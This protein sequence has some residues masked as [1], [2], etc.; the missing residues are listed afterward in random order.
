MPASGDYYGDLEGVEDIMGSSRGFAAVAFGLSLFSLEALADPP[1]LVIDAA[2]D[3]SNAPGSRPRQLTSLGGRVLFVADDDADVERLWASDGTLEGTYAL[4]PACPTTPFVGNWRLVA[5]LPGV[6]LFSHHCPGVGT[7]L[8][9]TDG[10]GS[11]TFELLDYSER[12]EVIPAVVFA[13]AVL[14]EES[15]AEPWNGSER[16]RLWRTDGTVEGTRRV[17]DVGLPG[18]ATFGAPVAAADRIELIVRPLGGLPE[19]WA[20]SGTTDTTRRVTTLEAGFDYDWSYEAVPFGHRVAWLA[21]PSQLWVSD[22]TVAGSG[23]VTAFAEPALAFGFARL[24]A[25]GERLLFV[26]NDEAGD[27]IWQSDGTPAGTRRLTDLEEP[28]ALDFYAGPRFL[29]PVGD[30]VLFLMVEPDGIPRLAAFD[31]LGGELEELARPCADETEPWD[32][33]V[34]LWLE[35]I[36]ERAVVPIPA[37]GLGALATSDGTVA[38]TGVTGRLCPTGCAQQ[39]WAP[40]RAGE[41]LFGLITPV[42]GRLELWSL[43]AGG[44]ATWRGGGITRMGS[45]PWSEPL[46]LA[47]AGDLL[48]LS[49]GDERHGV[50]LFRSSPGSTRLELVRDLA[51]DTA[52]AKIE[53]GVELAGDLYLAVEGR[54]LRTDGSRE[55]TFEL[56]EPPAFS[57]SRY[58]PGETADLRP[59]AFRLLIAN[60]DCEEGNLWSYDLATGELSALLGEARPDRPHFLVLQEGNARETDLLVGDWDSGATELWTTDGTEAGTERLIALPPGG[61]SVTRVGDTRFILAHGLY[62]W[63]PED[64]A[65][66]P[67]NASPYEWFQSYG[68]A[69]GR[70]LFRAG[71]FSAPGVALIAVDSGGGVETLAEFGE[72][73]WLRT[74][75]A[76][77]DRLLFYVDRSEDGAPEVWVTD[78]SAAGTRRLQASVPTLQGLD[79]ARSFAALGERVAF[80]GFSASGETELWTSDGSE[81][82]TQF[83]ARLTL[84]GETV[85]VKALAATGDRI[86]V[87]GQPTPPNGYP[88]HDRA[89]LWSSPDTPGVAQ[90]VAEWPL[91]EVAAMRLW[92]AEGALTTLGERAWFAG[93]SPGSGNELWTSDGTP[94]G[95]GRVA[96][97]APGPASSHPGSFTTAGGRLFFA[98]DDGLTGQELWSYE[99]GIG[100][101]CRATATAHCLQG[102][103]FRVE[104]GWMDFEGVQGEATAVPLSTDSGAFWFF[105]PANVELVAKV[106]DGR[107]PF[108]HFWVFFGALSNVRYAVTV[109]DG[110]TG[111]ARRYVNPAGTYASVGDTAAFG[112][113]G[114]SATGGPPPTDEVAATGGETTWL[115]AG[116]ASGACAASA[117]RLCLR[118]GRFAVEASWRDFQGNEGV[119]AAT[120]WSGGETGT[121]WFFDA[122]NVELIVKVLDGTP[123]NG[124]FWVYFGALSN[125]EYRVTVTDTV[126]GAV[127]TYFNPAGTFASVGDVDAF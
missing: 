69:G 107:V 44:E 116:E 8:W 34:Y 96:D 47:L 82:G 110:A 76:L 37:E 92:D 63:R 109:R 97:L 10:S 28:Y 87:L 112:P 24:T 102:G 93:A 26:A 64:A 4:G 104:A 62:R 53:P 29:V 106:L 50:E 61:A 83:L 78:G 27:E 57:C 66:L 30:R 58:Y 103:R 81:A 49:A 11:G 46:P 123:I 71:H 101:L 18:G 98:A 20:S 80:L 67:V 91:D 119:G 25:D 59:L 68:A 75:R 33:R 115:A 38:G 73:G 94:A 36:G 54:V 111:A 5:T 100:A 42:E 35:Q 117:T 77:G 32:C 125:V 124:R 90:R 72:Q 23:P 79:S 74:R 13:G 95:T 70:G 14:F 65:V 41:E 45:S 56:I 121:F 55:G 120:P 12:E 126:T 21:Y 31:R 122:A 1:R 51:F 19:V 6:A 15:L 127:R 99:P 43:D 9:R 48:L 17:V 86:F 60:G 40:T 89:W 85:E 2:T 7:R 22:G 84:G 105:D 88:A 114:A 52:H 39:P 113:L 3:L 118:D 108:E 16:L